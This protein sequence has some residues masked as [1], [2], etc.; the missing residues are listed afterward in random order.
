MKIKELFAGVTVAQ[1]V[2]VA[3]LVGG[4]VALAILLPDSRW[5]DALRLLAMVVAGGG[6]VGTLFLERRSSGRSVPPP[7]MDLDSGDTTV[8]SIPAPPSISKK[9]KGNAM[10]DALLLVIVAAGATFAAI[11]SRHQ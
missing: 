10:V 7:P 1:A 9:R 2:V 3:T 6:G 11:V 5:S 8:P 4:G